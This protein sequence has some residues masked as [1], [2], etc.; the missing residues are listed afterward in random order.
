VASRLDAT[1]DRHSIDHFWIV[2]SLVAAGRP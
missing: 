2:S 1:I